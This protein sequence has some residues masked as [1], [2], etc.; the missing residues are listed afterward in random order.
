MSTPF[1]ES[2]TSIEL[3]D[4]LSAGM[5]VL[6]EYIVRIA[7][8][9]VPFLGLPIIKQ[10]FAYI[11]SKVLEKVEGEGQLLISF[12]MIDVEIDKEV[13]EYKDAIESLKVANTTGVSDEERQLALK[14]AKDKLRALIRMPAP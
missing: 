1:K 5:S 8:A 2:A 14:L 6:E 9:Q 10:I 3:Q 11:L 13:K 12:K 4:S 7:I